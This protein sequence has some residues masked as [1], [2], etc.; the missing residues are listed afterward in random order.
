M[1]HLNLYINGQ[2]LGKFNTLCDTGSSISCVK[3]SLNG[4]CCN[5]VIKSIRNPVGASGLPLKNDGDILGQIEI[6]NKKYDGR[7]TLIA[8]LCYNI[9]L[10]TDILERLGFYINPD[11]TK[12]EIAGQ[13]I[14]RV[15]EN[16]SVN[17]IPTS[18]SCPSVNAKVLSIT[19][20]GRCDEKSVEGTNKG[21][22]SLANGQRQKTA[23]IPKNTY[24]TDHTENS[25][26]AIQH[27]GLSQTTE[28]SKTESGF[29]RPTMH[30]AIENCA[31]EGLSYNSPIAA[32]E[33]PWTGVNGCLLPSKKHDGSTQNGATL[34]HSKDKIRDLDP[35]EKS[36]VDNLLLNFDDIFSKSDE[37]LG[38]FCATDGG[39]STVTF[40]LKDPSNICYSVPRRVPY[41]RRVWL[42]DKLRSLEN[43]GIIKEVTHVDGI[44]H[45]SPVVIVPKKNNK[46]RMAVD[47]RKLNENLKFE[48]M[49]LPNIKDCIEKLSKKTFFTA[50]D[51]TSAFHQLELCE[52]TKKMTAFVTL[53][54]RYITH[55]MPFGAHPCPAK[56]QE[57]MARVFRSVS[58]DKCTVYMDDILV[59]SE[60]FEDHLK[61]LE[62]I[63]CQI[64]RHGFKLSPSKCSYFKR[65]IEYLGFFVGE[66]GGKLGYSPLPSKISAL[67][68]RT[69]P[70]TAKE[71]RSFCG[72]LQFYNS[73]IPKLNLMLAPLHKGA[74]KTPF[75][76]SDKMKEAFYTVKDCLKEK[77]M[78][79][80][81]DFTLPFKLSTDASYEGAAGI[82]SQCYPDGKEEIIHA[83]SKSFDEVQTKWA[84]CELECLA[85]VWSLDKMK[86]LLLGIPFTWVTDSKVLKQ[87]LEN[88]PRDLS[89][90]GRKIQR[91]VDFINSFQI[92]IRHEK[93]DNP[94]TQLADFFSRAPVLA[95]K[96][97]FRAQIT[98]NDWVKA[99]VND[100]KLTDCNGDWKKYQKKLFMEDDIA[101]LHSTPRCKIAVPSALQDTVVKYYHESYTLHAGVSRMIQVITG[102]YFWPNMYKTIKDYVTNCQKCLKSKSLPMQSGS[103]VAIQTPKKP[104]EWVQID[105]V[106]VSKKTSD[107]G[108]RY[109]LTCICCLTNYFQMEP[110]PSKETI[111]VLKALCKI[112]CQTG[113]P[114]IIQSDNGKEFYSRIMQTHAK[115]LDVEW[116]FSTPYKPST[117]GRIERRHAD[118]GKLLKI[119][120]CDDNNWCDELPFITFELN[121]A[122]DRI[123]GTSPFE[124][125]HGWSPRIPHLIKDVEMATPETDFFDWSHQVDKQSWEERLRMHQTRAFSAIREQ[126][127]AHKDQNALFGS[128]SAQLVPG[129]T[130]MVK[131]PGGGKLQPKLHG[132]YKVTKV[133][134]GGSITAEEIN[135][136]KTVRLPAHCARR[137]KLN[138]QN[139]QSPPDEFKDQ[140]NTGDHDPTPTK[141]D[142]GPRTRKKFVDYTKFY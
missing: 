63:F 4:L 50:L 72:G 37:D 125:F 118:L 7:F 47:Y 93:G 5:Q 117:N 3:S 83:F 104:F 84:I 79:A 67:T 54:K 41:G 116:R 65:N 51:I 122:V 8:N 24:P 75:V 73:I 137:L 80:F 95:I 134:I 66:H 89:R 68:A 111:V 90:S 78:L 135:G 25:T 74:A 36:L 29:T 132:P 100:N 102:L 128:L 113:I 43:A 40:H 58:P 27:N 18:I 61:D 16:D 105:L 33:E 30:I 26:D 142:T 46:F 130:V 91:Y 76:M 69:L 71:V 112:F 49:P 2:H 44:L 92:T 82:L 23:N 42:E 53:G 109:I 138:E 115:W 60:S 55:R 107:R 110:I 10:G 28:P 17:C 19:Q 57:T 114:K 77:I 126:R 127:M 22:A 99:T 96:D 106:T 81:P 9:I 123:T 13:E 108:N 64:R 31:L 124:Q 48:T 119:L 12:V 11:G 131:L 88:P 136:S 86:E 94:E 35:T 97:L 141:E 39:P 20:K 62:E 6:G 15:F 129:D 56:F 32:T 87:M 103:K 101:Y 98:K 21:T 59:H 52:E 140:P 121:A 133:N 70:K 38:K 34:Y 14:C 45:V 85:L 1:V 120:E 139:E